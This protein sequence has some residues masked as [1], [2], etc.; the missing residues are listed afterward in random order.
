MMTRYKLLAFAALLSVLRSHAQLLKPLVD[1]PSAKPAKPPVEAA[2]QG[3]ST[4][5]CELTGFLCD[6]TSTVGA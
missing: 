1:H 3:A 5:L 4:V 2:L 6:D